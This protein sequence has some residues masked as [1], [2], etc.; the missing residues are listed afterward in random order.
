L[1]LPR[2]KNGGVFVLSRKATISRLAVIISRRYG[3]G[4][5]P[6]LRLATLI[7]LD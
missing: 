6:L 5:P 2:R 1:K 4:E 7:P 3:C